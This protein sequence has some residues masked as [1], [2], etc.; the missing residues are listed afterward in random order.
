[1][2]TTKSQRILMIATSNTVMGA[3]GKPTG[4]WAD[5]LAVP[6]Y[7]LTDAGAEVVLA[8]PLGGAITLDP[9]SLKPAG[10]NDPLVDR[11][12]ADPVA[13]AAAKT[14]HV[15][16][17]MDASGFDA[18]FFPGGHGT[19]WDLPTDAGVTRA[20]ETAFAAGKLIASVCHGAAGLVTA[21]RPDGEPV[22]KGQRINSFTDAEEEAVGLTGIVPFALE[23][24][25]RAL[26]AHFEGADNWTAFAIRDGQ[27]ITGQNPQSSALVA[28]QVLAALGLVA[29]AG[30]AA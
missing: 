19:M 22:V 6:Y 23:S 13:Q 20:V 17:Q 12:L 18:V 3:S 2:S 8:S 26:G 16:A 1:M 28:E 5:E 27:F 25:L 10:Q 14:T 29:K 11:F 7:L 21:R 4:I 15:A 9:G 30:I 24:R